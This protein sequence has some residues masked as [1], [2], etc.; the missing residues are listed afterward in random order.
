MLIFA[1]SLVIVVEFGGIVFLIY[2]GTKVAMDAY[3]DGYREGKEYEINHQGGRHGKDIQR[4][5]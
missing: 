2:H 4:Q 3:S 1:L 5:K